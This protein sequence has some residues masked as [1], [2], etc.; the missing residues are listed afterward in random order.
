M[1]LLAVMAGCMARVVWADLCVA[2]AA[3]VLSFSNDQGANAA[4]VG[5]TPVP[6]RCGS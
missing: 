1:W 2:G 4:A 5:A 6:S 3:G